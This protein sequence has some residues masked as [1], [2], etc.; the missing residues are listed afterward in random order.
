LWRP[1]EQAGE[2]P[3]AVFE[4]YG[5]GRRWDPFE[6]L[7]TGAHRRGIDVWAYT[8]PNYQGAL[9]PNPHS[10]V[11][12]RL[13][14]L[15]LAPFADAHPEYWARDGQGVDALV[16]GGYVILSLAFPEVRRYLVSQMVQLVNRAG[17]DG[18]E[19]EWLVGQERQSP[20]DSGVR[21]SEELGRVTEFVCNVR[22]AVHG[23][24]KLSSAVPADQ[25]RARGWRIDWPDW[26]RRGLVDQVVLRLRGNDIHLL[27]TEVRAARDSCGP[28]AW[29]IAQLDC[30][31]KDG[32]RDAGDLL[33]AADVARE[34]GADEVGVYRADSVETANLWPAVQQIGMR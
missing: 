16:R 31:H 33:R 32:W 7:V 28:Q 13:P 29:L 2:K 5:G 11:G 15:F 26:A 8:S 30:W 24:A 27:E 25:D 21:P 10:P 18:L 14:L 17:L 22:G 4:L 34:A 1:G 3:L 12:E 9:Q 23:R 19:L 6:E 20:Y